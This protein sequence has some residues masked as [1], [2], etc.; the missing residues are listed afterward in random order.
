MTEHS[1]IVIFQTALEDAHC[2]RVS[3]L[4]LAHNT[5]LTLAVRDLLCVSRFTIMRQHNTSIRRKPRRRTNWRHRHDV[6]SSR[7]SLSL[8]LWQSLLHQYNVLFMASTASINAALAFIASNINANH[9]SMRRNMKF[10]LLFWLSFSHQQMV[11]LTCIQ[12]IAQAHHALTWTSQENRAI[13]AFPIPH[14]R[15]IDDLNDAWCYQYTRFTKLPLPF[16]KGSKT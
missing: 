1:W 6:L 9:F 13:E 5:F 4:S 12:N 10:M 15:R 7:D 11:T 2:R 3:P 14:N 8:R 16:E